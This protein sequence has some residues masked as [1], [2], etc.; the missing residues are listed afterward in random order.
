MILLDN[1]KLVLASKSPR[2]NELLKGLGVDFT[3]RTK[4]TDES[5]PSDMDPFEVAGFLSKKKADAF[6]PELAKD[7]ILITADTVVILDGAILNKPSDKKEAF[8]MIASLSGKVHHVVTG[9]TIGSV[10]RHIT[11]QDSVKVHFKTLTTEEINYYIEKFQPFDKAGAYGIQEWIGYIAV[12][13]IEGSFYTVMGLPVHLV[14]E[15]L[16]IITQF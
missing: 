9:I 5:F 15:Q 8:E 14:Y 10:S 13:S 7:E 12:D 3:V 2:R 6:F 4:D 11:L 16:K 1:Y